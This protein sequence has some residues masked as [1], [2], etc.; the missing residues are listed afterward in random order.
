MYRAAS[1]LLLGLAKNW[2]AGESLEDA[3][4]RTRFANSKGM[5]G[6]INLLGEHSKSPSAI[7][8]NTQEYSRM[9][10]LVKQRG[11]RSSISVKP[12]QLGLIVSQ[13]LFESNLE[14]LAKEALELGSF[15]WLDMESSHYTDSTLDAY[16]KLYERYK[17]LGVALQANLQRT[18]ADLDRLIRARG[19]VRL[20][21]GAYSE[22]SG[23]AF[24]SR[25]ETDR[26]YLDLMRRL[27]AQSRDFAIATHDE[28]MIQEAVRLRR[29]GD[30]WFEFQMLLG[31]RND[32]KPNLIRQGYVLNEYIPYGRDW[33]PYSLRR[34]NE[35][36][37]NIILLA[38]SL[39]Q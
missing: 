16:L 11:L 19:R 29:S 22:P 31:I 1:R 35:R 26:R 14:F 9:L 32:L 13:S 39:F 5:G 15:V 8:A 36:K 38:R 37:R 34:I 21:K 12:T 3:L 23:I 27:F 30:A 2:M 4:V 7:Q 10:K 17:N 20:V 6:I 24:R 25:K 18:S 28:K 33:L